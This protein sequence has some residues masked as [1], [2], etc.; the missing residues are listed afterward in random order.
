[1]KYI[2]FTPEQQI[3][4]MIKVKNNSA[5][6]WK[7]IIQELKMS[8]AMVFCYLNGSSKIPEH[9]YYKL[10]QLGNIKTEIFPLIEIKNKT[11]PILL[12]GK[13]D[14]RLAELVG[15]I[16][17]DGHVS[18]IN[19]EISI[20]CHKILDRHYIFEHVA[21]L[22][23]E[24]FEI[25]PKI[26]DAKKTKGIKCIVNSK[27]LFYFMTE[28]FK[29]PAGKK[30]GRLLIPKEIEENNQWLK[31]YIRGLFDTDGSIYFRR[32]KSMVISIISAD[33][34]FLD[35]VRQALKTLGYS[36][37]VSGKNL[38]I[39]D[40]SQIKRFFNEI[41]PANKKHNDKYINFIKQNYVLTPNASVV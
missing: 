31:A 15:I 27:I 36:P 13:I 37:S 3:E 20:T 10:C 34:I 23:K 29:H 40:Q 21:K 11:E 1:M 33:A 22:F 9:N 35:Q 4:F 41:N 2:N 38:Y 39:Y 24:L 5:L 7:T 25:T 6:T 12:P 28:K 26:R 17:G 8:R 16:A 32:E 19:Y 14:E 30:K 18:S